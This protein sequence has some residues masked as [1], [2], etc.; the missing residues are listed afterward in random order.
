MGRTNNK[1]KLSIFLKIFFT[2]ILTIAVTFIAFVT[3]NN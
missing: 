1:N 2:T 3:I